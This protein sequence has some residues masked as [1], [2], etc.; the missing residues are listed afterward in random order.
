[1]VDSSTGGSEI[2][3]I[4]TSAGM[5]F[6]R[7]A[8]TS[9]ACPACPVGAHPPAPAA[10]GARCRCSRAA[11]PCPFESACPARSGEDDVIA[12]IE[13]RIARWTL[14]PVGNGEG[15]QVLNYK[16]GAV[17]VA[18]PLGEGAPP[19]LGCAG[20]G[21]AA[22]TQRL[23]LCRSLRTAARPGISGSLGECMRS[24]G[25]AAGWLR[26]ERRRLGMA[27]C[28]APH[29]PHI[30]LFLPAP[31]Y[32]TPSR[33]TSLTQRQ[34][35]LG[36]RGEGGGRGWWP[37]GDGRKGTAGVSLLHGPSPPFPLPNPSTNLW[38]QRT[39]KT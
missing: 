21:S 7:C 4:R 25:P 16:V 14:L 35:R 37:Q 22:A 18:A 15:L 5:F 36:A 28:A 11:H 38:C 32:V 8:H 19:G 24:A 12:S 27:C 13:E 6:E 9:A 34:G 10:P 29:L 1:M 33:T 26:A 39:R 2:S 23:A 30:L 17:R 31:L 3:D 20:S